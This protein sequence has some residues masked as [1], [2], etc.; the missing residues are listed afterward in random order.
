MLRRIFGEGLDYT[1][2]R[3]KPGRPATGKN[4]GALALPELIYLGS[5][6]QLQLDAA[7]APVTR[8]LV[9]EGE[10]TQVP[11]TLLVHELVHAWQN[12]HG[13]SNYLLEAA[14][15]YAVHG[16][17]R[18]YDWWNYTDH[19]DHLRVD[20]L[21]RVGRMGSDWRDLPVEPQAQFIDDAYRLGAFNGDRRAAGSLQVSIRSTD[22]VGAREQASYAAAF[23]AGAVIDWSQFLRGAVEALHAGDFRY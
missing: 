7:G 16:M 23:G 6:G 9:P 10:T 20:S 5:T 17:D 21:D 4:S 22:L 14:G 1:A 19:N 2:V 18:S 12:Q 3:L 15:G 13:G 11:T 8:N